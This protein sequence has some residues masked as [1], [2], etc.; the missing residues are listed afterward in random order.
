MC[1]RALK[2]DA[3]RV[4]TLDYYTRLREYVREEICC[5]VDISLCCGSRRVINDVMCACVRLSVLLSGVDCCR[6]GGWLKKKYY[7]LLLD[8]LLDYPR[9]AR[10]VVYHLR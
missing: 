2:H 5:E 10:E 7:N 8:Y 3:F 4:S 9:S 1:D 6:S